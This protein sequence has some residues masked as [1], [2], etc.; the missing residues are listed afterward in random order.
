[1]DW[2]YFEHKS[3]N[4]LVL[5]FEEK[6]HCYFDFVPF[7]VKENSY[8]PIECRECFKVLIFWKY[9][10]QNIRRFKKMVDVF[11]YTIIGKYNGEVVVFYV[12]KKDNVKIFIN[13]LEEQVNK[14][15]VRGDIQWRVSGRYWQD[16]YPQFFKSAKEL[17]DSHIENEV[18][19]SKW[20]SE[21]NRMTKLIAKIAEGCND[22]D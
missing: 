6:E 22:N 7:F 15:N 14:F 8:L 1:M 12:R 19:I 20:L 4:P 13:T 17:I 9:N 3:L 10:L 11:P 2:K 21:N 5:T 16:K 18:S